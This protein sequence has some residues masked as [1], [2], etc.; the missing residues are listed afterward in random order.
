MSENNAKKK[1]SFGEAWQR[2]GT[3]GIFVLLLIVLAVIKPSSVFSASSVPQILKQSSVNILLALGEF[4]A[5]LIAGIDLS[6]GSVAALTGLFTAKMMIAGVPVPLAIL[7]GILIGTGFGF[8]NG[9]LVNK[10]GLHPF[11]I[12]LG[13][14]SIFRGIPL[15][16]PIP[17]PYMD[18]RYPLL[19]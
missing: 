18:S 1:M 8:I 5:I 15:Y 13:T 11:I 17:V 2:F 12:T 7:A 3:I 10:T 16:Y 4:F 6:V 19:H 14:Q 9:M